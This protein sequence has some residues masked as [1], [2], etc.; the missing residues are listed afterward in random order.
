LPISLLSSTCPTH[1]S[2]SHNVCGA[3]DHSLMF[4]AVVKTQACTL[5]AGMRIK[6][7]SSV[8]IGTGLRTGRSGVCFPLDARDFN[9]SFSK[10]RPAVVWTQPLI[11]SVPG[12]PSM[13]AEWL[14]CEADRS[15]PCRTDV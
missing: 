5:T 12:V 2:H 15:P 7:G 13:G 10:I 1:P 11:H 4:C 6:V 14:G 9:V 8:S 3:T